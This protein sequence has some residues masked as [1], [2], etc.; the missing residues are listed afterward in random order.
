MEEVYERIVIIKTKK[1][2]KSDVNKDLQW[3]SRSL[4][5]FNERDKEKSCFRIFVELTKASKQD[6]KLKTDDIAQ[7]A[8]LSRATVFH[9]LNNLME[10]GLV[11]S[12]NNKY[13][14]RESNFENLLE[15]I[16][17][18]FSKTL[19]DLKLKAKE[20]DKELDNF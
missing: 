4:G 5:L 16:E 2:E 15:D 17:R 9:H 18:D 14:L 6:Q 13:L 8:H 10:R 12:K 7:K 20:L 11:I 19:K 1:P 3:F